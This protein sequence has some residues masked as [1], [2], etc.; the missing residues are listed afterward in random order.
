MEIQT[1]LSKGGV[2]YGKA[3]LFTLYNVTNVAQ[4]WLFS[5]V[6]TWLLMLGI[7]ELT[8]TKNEAAIITNYDRIRNMSIDEMASYFCIGGL[9]VCP[10]HAPYCKDDKYPECFKKWLES[11]VEEE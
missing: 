2:M 7:G 3:K 8:M 5:I 9:P 4:E 10:L 1:Q 11:E 6:Y